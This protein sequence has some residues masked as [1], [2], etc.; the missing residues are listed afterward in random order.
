MMKFNTR[1]SGK[2]YDMLLT[3]VE[4]RHMLECSFDLNGKPMSSFKLNSFN[5]PAYSGQDGHANRRE[6]ACL[7][8]SGPIPPGSYYI[9][10][11][12][13]GGLLG[14]L[15]DL[16]RDHDDWFALYA[17]DGKIDDET[18]CSGGKRGNFRLHP[19]GRMGISRGCITLDKQSDF[20]KLRALL[21]S[22]KQSNVP[23]TTLQAY[24]R[25]VVR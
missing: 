5:F 16:F 6:L 19:R 12:Q 1:A 9:F 14:P 11:R 15:W 13:S 25:V 22:A 3:L 17:L 7:A 2:S 10:D 4:N 23:G 8:N 18:F 24:G 21:K 20:Y